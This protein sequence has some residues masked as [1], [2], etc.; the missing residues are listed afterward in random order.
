MLPV[1]IVSK[2]AESRGYPDLDPEHGWEQWQQARLE[3]I[4]ENS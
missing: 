1:S 2:M 4:D 3:L